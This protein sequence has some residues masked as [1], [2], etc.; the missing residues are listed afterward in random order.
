MRRFYENIAAGED[1][2]QALAGSKSTVL[3]QFGTAALPSVAAFQLV[4]VG[5]YRVSTPRA[6]AYE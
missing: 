4:G 1:V 2:A 3:E 6:G 5:D